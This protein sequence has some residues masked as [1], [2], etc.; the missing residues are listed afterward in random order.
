MIV[1]SENEDRIKTQRRQITYALIGFVFLNI[2][3]AIYSVFLPSDKNGAIIGTDTPWKNTS[4]GTIFWDTYGFDG[5]FGS[6]I[7]FFRVFIF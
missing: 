4:S 3:G 5:I 6:L 7:A 1:F 2:P